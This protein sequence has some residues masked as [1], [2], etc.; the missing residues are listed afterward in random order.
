LDHDVGDLWDGVRRREGGSELLKALAAVATDVGLAPRCLLGRDTSR[1]L[2]RA[3][4]RH[5]SLREVAGDLSEPH[6]LT[7][8]VSQRRDE[9]VRPEPRAILP[10]SPPFVLV[11]P[12]LG[13]DPQLVFRKAFGHSLGWIEDREVLADDL[14][15]RVALDP[16]PAHPPARPSRVH[17]D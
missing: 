15:G 9:D 13:R 7:A 5:P 2:E 16:L 10:H 6:E 8:L 14:L 3:L 1:I 12:D 4:L 11:L 17:R